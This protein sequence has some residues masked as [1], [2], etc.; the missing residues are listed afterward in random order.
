MQVRE[1]VSAP[2]E[3]RLERLRALPLVGLGL[4]WARRTVQIAMI[5][6]GMGLAAQF[7]ASLIPLILVIAALAPARKNPDFWNAV[8]RWLGLRGASAHTIQQLIGTGGQ[9]QVDTTW[10]GAVILV[11]SALSFIRALQRAFEQV[12][13]LKPLSLKNTPREMVWLGFLLVTLWIGYQIRRVSLQTVPVGPL[14]IACYVLAG[15]LFWWVTPYLLMGGRIGLR[16][17]LPGAVLTC[18]AVDVYGLASIVYMPGR[19]NASVHQY[20]PL[21]LIFIILSWYFILFCIVIGGAAIGPTL[22]EEDNALARFMRGTDRT[23]K[24]PAAS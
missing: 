21:G 1:L 23:G 15:V 20:G 3:Q 10:L 19:I 8:A 7:V 18:L 4:R 5:D 2:K 24:D 14:L 12:W 16:L 9:L 22:L 6:R 13:E 11:V 17:L